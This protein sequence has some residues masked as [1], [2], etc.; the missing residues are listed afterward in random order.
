MKQL[1]I[2]FL[3]CL[4]MTCCDTNSIEQ[5][6]EPKYLTKADI[7]GVW[8]Y[9]AN[10]LYFISLSESGRYT[11]CFNK[12]IMGAGTY[13][14]EKDILTLNN[15]YLY[16]SD[17]LSI[18]IDNNKL[19]LKGNML[20]YKS[21]NSS[22]IDMSFSKSNESIS[23]SMIGVVKREDPSLVG[24]PSGG[25]YSDKE[26]EITY[27]SDYTATYQL[28]GKLSSTKQWVVIEEEIWHY[29]YRTPNTYTQLPNGDGEVTIYFLDNQL[30]NSDIETY[31][32]EQ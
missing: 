7:S 9:P 16:T 1:S 3:S 21:N 30:A 17:K 19:S 6:E 24:L 10:E 8:A 14:L 18:S 27:T 26:I 22:Y 32:V 31:I 2:L 15:G 28:E 29:V 5:P 4:I 25:K 12:Y 23:S 13:E 11:L 20:K